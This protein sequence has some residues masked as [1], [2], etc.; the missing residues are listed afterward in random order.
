MGCLW[1]WSR[2]ADQQLCWLCSWILAQDCFLSESNHRMVLGPMAKIIAASF[3]CCF[4]ADYSCLSILVTSLQLTA[5]QL[6]FWTIPK[7]DVHF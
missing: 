1:R 2:G 3:D 5:F 7:M 6:L 4:P